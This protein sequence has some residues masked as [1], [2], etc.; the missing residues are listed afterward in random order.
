[1]NGCSFGA[2]LVPHESGLDA[3]VGAFCGQMGALH[4]FEDVLTL[5]APLLSIQYA[6]YLPP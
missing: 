1:M 5:G 3:E 6:V 2:G 4:L